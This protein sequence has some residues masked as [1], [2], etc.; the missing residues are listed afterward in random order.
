MLVAFFDL[1][2]FCGSELSIIIK[3]NG[4]A[5]SF[6]KDSLSHDKDASE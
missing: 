6:C 3:A 5:T 1:H 2:S 4:E